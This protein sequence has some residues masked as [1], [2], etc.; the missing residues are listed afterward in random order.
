MFHSVGIA[1]RE[2]VRQTEAYLLTRAVAAFC[3]VRV[4]IHDS[5]LGQ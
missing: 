5:R 2:V 3:S 4:C 1:R